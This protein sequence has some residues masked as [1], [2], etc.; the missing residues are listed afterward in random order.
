MSIPAVRAQKRQLLKKIKKRNV[1]TIS[2]VFC[3]GI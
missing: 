3:I 2:S 1:D